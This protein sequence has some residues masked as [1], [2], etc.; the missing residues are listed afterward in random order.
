MNQFEDIDQISS[1]A[2]N[3]V[4]TTRKHINSVNSLC[5]VIAKHALATTAQTNLIHKG[6]EGVENLIMKTA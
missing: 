2:V 4:S 1:C 6:T 5:V 3:L